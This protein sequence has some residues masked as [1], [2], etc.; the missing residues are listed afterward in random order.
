MASVE[1]M[2]AIDPPPVT[3]VMVGGTGRSGTTVIAGLLGR[4][5]QIRAS[6]PREVK[7]LTESGGLLDLC[8][9]ASSHPRQRS[10]RQVRVSAPVIGRGLAHY[11]FRRN[12]R[13]RWWERTNRMG[14][15]SGL[16]LALDE[17]TR[18]ELLA[19][20]G[21]CLALGNRTEAGRMF[22]EQLIRAQSQDAGEPLWVDTSP[23]NIA[24]ADRLL[25]LLPASRF[26]WMVRDGRSTAA[27][28][29]AE[30]WGPSDPQQAISWWEARLRQSYAG[31]ADVP[32]D[33][34]LVVQ[35]EDL[36]VRE[37]RATYQ[38]LLEFLEVEDDPAMQRFFERRMPA[39]RSR[40]D[41]WR[42]RV[43]DPIAF[44]GA[45]LRA[46]DRL[47]RDGLATFEASTS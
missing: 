42:E 47:E 19:E 41:A 37:R 24:E 16:H 7:F 29:L 8:V 2:R 34:V 31:V 36:V 26:V 25:T 10:R 43:R 1:A 22:V 4:H 13:R 39:G 45:Y 32:A 40:P 9:G 14:R 15:R 28:V 38:R 17:S 6:V 30:R 5:R 33:R 3:P 11:R 44:E 21:Q 18:E 20:L 35:L 27:S 46:R 12:M 23:P